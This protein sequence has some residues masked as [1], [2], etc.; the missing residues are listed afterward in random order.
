MVSFAWG[1]QSCVHGSGIDP[2]HRSKCCQ[3]KDTMFVSRNSTKATALQ[4]SDV[5]QV[6]FLDY[7]W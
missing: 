4:V 3:S 1:M 7:S 2:V 6:A 5:E